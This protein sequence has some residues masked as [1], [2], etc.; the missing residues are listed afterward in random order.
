[1]TYPQQGGQPQHGYGGGPQ[2]A[3]SQPGA[4]G[5]QAPQYGPP[6]GQVP[7]GAPQRAQGAHRNPLAEAAR[8]APIGVALLGVA[9]FF[10]GFGP[11]LDGEGG[12]AP[13]FFGSMFGNPLV[14]TLVLIAG[15][16]AALGLIPR[17]KPN[18]GT[19][20]VASIAAALLLLCSLGFSDINDFFSGF[21]G[22][23]EPGVGAGWAFW[24]VFAVAVA[25]AAL[26]LIAVFSESGLIRPGGGRASAGWGYGRSP[27]GQYGYGA[28]SQFGAAPQQGHA[29]QYGQSPQY[30]QAPQYGQSPRYGQAPQYGPGPRAAAEGQPQPYPGNPGADPRYA[31]QPPP[32][33][34]YAPGRYG[35]PAPPQHGG[36]PRSAYGRPGEE[37]AGP[38][39]GAPQQGQP[40][41]SEDQTRT[42]GAV[43]RDDTPGSVGGEDR[44]GTSE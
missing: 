8:Y 23:S 4:H 28:P 12:D 29:P 31:Q 38:S 22:S 26:A 18:L 1:M 10:L 16:N 15:L 39:S 37:D 36:D 3:P 14:V 11:Y 7:Y 2:G 6:Q 42:F 32:P 20:A 9:G 5:Q 27:G 30:G 33:A 34:G 24:L 44:D 13:D 21:G 43:R 25:Q 17:Q 40:E 41:G 19:S 35:Q